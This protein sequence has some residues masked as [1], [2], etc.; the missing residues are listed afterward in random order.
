[1]LVGTINPTHTLVS[2]KLY[3]HSKENIKLI[4]PK[5]DIFSLINEAPLINEQQIPRKWIHLC[6]KITGQI[7]YEENLKRVA[8]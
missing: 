2:V 8:V 7:C 3:H 5:L 1:M 4:F 6:P